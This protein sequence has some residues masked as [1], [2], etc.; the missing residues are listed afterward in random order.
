VPK[1]RSAENGDGSGAKAAERLV[2]ILN[3]LAEEGRPLSLAEVAEGAGLAQATAHRLLNAFVAT[4]WVDKDPATSRYRLGH[5]MLG[6]AAVAL[7]HAP[8]IERGQPILT[9]M[10]EI[11]DANVL[12]GVLLGRNVVFLAMGS[13]AQ[14]SATLR[15]G[16]S[17]PAH[18][19][20]AGKVLLAFLTP[21]ERKRVFRGRKQLRQFTPNTITSVDELERHLE[22]VRRK[23]YALDMGEY[24]EYQR[25][26]AVPIHGPDG[27]VVAAMTCTGRAEKMTP[28]RMA[29]LHEEMSILAEEISRQAGLGYD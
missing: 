22:E 24:R 28:E 18:C 9:R 3:V 29:R 21:E 25:S 17:R 6:P 13:P 2:A 1:L 4:G 12:L 27:R 5:A 23:G 16:L 14:E 19:S 26:V 11:A 7:A 8:L 15:P 10:S 20:A